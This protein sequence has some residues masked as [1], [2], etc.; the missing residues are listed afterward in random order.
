MTWE[1]VSVNADHKTISLLSRLEA[2][3]KHVIVTEM[4][5]KTLSW[6]SRLVESTTA[7]RRKACIECECGK[8]IVE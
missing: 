6:K 3:G 5:F 8:C 1:K 2:G 7:N 4:L